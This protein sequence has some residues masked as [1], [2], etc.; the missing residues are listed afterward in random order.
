MTHPDISRQLFTERNDRLMAE[1][2]A[3]RLTKQ[4]RAAHRREAAP[5]TAVPWWPR[6][7]RRRSSPAMICPPQDRLAL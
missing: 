7:L 5:S 3:H 2:A 6:W 1:A 4:A